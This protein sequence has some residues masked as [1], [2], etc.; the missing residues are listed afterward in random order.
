MTSK[1]RVFVLQKQKRYDIS[2]V[3]YYSDEIIYVVNNDEHISP[4]DTDGFIELVTHRLIMANFNPEIDFICLTGS[5]ILLALFMASIGSCYSYANLKI[6]MF[7][8][9]TTNYKLRLLNLRS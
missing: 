4:F 3:K 6:L 1:A 8:A 7:D 2:A 9:R 5:S